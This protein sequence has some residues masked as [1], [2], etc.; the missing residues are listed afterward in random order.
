MNYIELIRQWFIDTFGFEPLDSDII[1]FVIHTTDH[2][3]GNLIK[4]TIKRLVLF[5][6]NKSFRITNE[7]YDKLYKIFI[8]NNEV[9]VTIGNCLACLCAARYLSLPIKEDKES[10]PDMVRF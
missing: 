5:P 10:V 1:A 2:T 9:Y 6:E 7:H 8:R 4:R 3:Y